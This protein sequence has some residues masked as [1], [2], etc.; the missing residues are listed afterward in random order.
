MPNLSSH[1][2]LGDK[3]TFAGLGHGFPMA[4]LTRIHFVSEFM[5]FRSGADIATIDWQGTDIGSP[6]SPTETIV[7]NIGT[8]SLHLDAGSANASGTN[9]TH[10]GTGALSGAGEFVTALDNK[11]IVFITRFKKTV[12]GA[13]GPALFVGLNRGVT[14]LDTSG[15]P[16]AVEYVGFWT[17]ID[18]AN[19]RFVCLRASGAAVDID[20]GITLSDDTWITVGFRID[21]L[22]VSETTGNGSVSAYTAVESG[23]PTNV[24]QFRRNY[25]DGNLGPFTRVVDASDE[26]VDQVPSGDMLPAT[27]IVNTADDA[28][29]T[30]DI[31]FIYVS[32]TR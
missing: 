11:S 31:D 7:S 17:G 2:I 16:A 21:A 25:L 19:L 23:G 8:T 10:L 14:V 15:D 3:N 6:T 1:G 5:D 26:L 9:F 29:L 12:A 32:Q 22:D 18:S 20:T 28:S 30:A 4:E 27:A 13:D 24:P